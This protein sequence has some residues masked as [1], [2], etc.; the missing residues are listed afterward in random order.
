LNENPRAT[1]KF[2][3]SGELSWNGLV[4]L[5]PIINYRPN[6]NLCVDAGV[7]LSAG[8]GYKFGI[9]GRYLFRPEGASP[10]VGLGYIASSGTMGQSI[11]IK[12]SETGDSTYI[13]VEQTNQLQLTGGFEKLFTNGF[14]LHGCLGWAVNLSDNVDIV[15]GT[16]SPALSAAMD[17][18]FKGGF[19]F[20]LGLGFAF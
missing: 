16:P 3:I 12:D 14:L 17:I 6:P 19:A 8:L 10:Y 2:G 15:K 9:R 20:A 4:G 18:L 11:G 1:R 13:I 7:G 5:G